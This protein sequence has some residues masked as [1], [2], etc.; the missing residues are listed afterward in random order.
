MT[1]PAEIDL[2]IGQKLV[3]VRPWSC[4]GLEYPPGL[5][6]DYLACSVSFLGLTRGPA[7]P[8][9]DPVNSSAG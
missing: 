9:S 4:E 1:R 5:V 8:C 6:E 3:P 7:V 2:I